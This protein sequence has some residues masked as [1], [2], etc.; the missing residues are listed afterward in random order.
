MGRARKKSRR[1]R[2]NPKNSND[3]G[4]R[5]NLDRD[6]D[7][8][9]RGVEHNNHALP[10]QRRGREYSNNS[11][12]NGES[13]DGRASK[14]GNPLS[15]FDKNPF[16]PPNMDEATYQDEQGSRFQQPRNRNRNRTRNRNQQGYDNYSRHQDGPHNTLPAN[17]DGTNNHAQGQRR[18]QKKN[19]FTPSITPPPPPSP[20]PSSQAGPGR[21]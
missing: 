15:S 17:N 13:R 1:S 3:N 5:H 20:Q 19:I 18:T 9:M 16:T 7:F 4:S 2:F 11:N 10:N 8:I 6:D 14:K 21:P 12:N